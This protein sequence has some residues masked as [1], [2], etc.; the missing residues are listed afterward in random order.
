[1]TEIKA[2]KPC[3]AKMISDLIRRLKMSRNIGIV[4]QVIRSVLGLGFIAYFLRETGPVNGPALSGFF[5]A[6]LLATALLLHCPLY[7][8]LGLSTCGRLDSTL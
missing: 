4:D 7:N 3:T 5:G 1:L 6:W 2:K 8:V